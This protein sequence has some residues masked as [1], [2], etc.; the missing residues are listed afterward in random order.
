MEPAVRAGKERLT[1]IQVGAQASQGTAVERRIRW[2][3]ADPQSTI[4]FAEERAREI[5]K[6]TQQIV[7]INRVRV[8]ADQ[9]I[10]E[11]RLG[12]V[13]SEAVLR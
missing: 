3:Q 8:V 5:R 4:S 9:A 10:G 11:A 13:G 12:I 1:Q 2:L 7:H 6:R